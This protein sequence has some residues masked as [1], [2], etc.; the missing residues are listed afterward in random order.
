[1][2]SDLEGDSADH[3]RKT[4]SLNKM[5]YDAQPVIPQRSK[6]GVPPYCVHQHSF[7]YNCAASRA[8]KFV[9]LYLGSDAVICLMA[10]T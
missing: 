7:V 5:A 1:M 6:K 3:T 8:T 9:S 4:I 10:I 2:G